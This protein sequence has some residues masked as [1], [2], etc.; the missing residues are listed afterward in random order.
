[1]TEYQLPA[2]LRD[3][4]SRGLAQ[5]A[6]ANIGAGSPPIVSLMGNR[7]TLVDAVGTDEQVTTHDPKLGVYLDCCVVDVGDHESKIYF[8]AA[9]DP[10]ATSWP[11]PKCWSD[12]GVAPS[13]Q[14]GEP[15]AR[16]CTP[17]PTGQFGCKWAVWGS[18]TSKVSGKGVPACG[19]YQKLAVVPV[20]DEMAFLLRVPPNSL[21]NLQAYLAKFK[22]DVGPEHVVTRIWFVSQG[23][24][25][26]S[27]VNYIDEAMAGVQ[28]KLRADKATD[29]LVGRNDQPIAL[30]P[31]GAALPAP[32]QAQEQPRP[33]P[34]RESAQSAV[35]QSTNAAMPSHSTTAAHPAQAASPSDPP[36][37]QGGQ[38]RRRRT[39]AEMAAASG[40]QPAAGGA[41]PFRPSEP[42]TGAQ[43][44][45]G[46]QDGAAPGADL[47]RELD[48]LFGPAAGR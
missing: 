3:L 8:G 32:Q 9:F 34:P 29:N 35:S 5:R 37:P 38:R 44:Q 22:G 17:D 30:A 23:T 46:M 40:G 1:M 21:S 18:A 28:K 47:D 31:A 33:L 4:P 14:A 48:G 41:A 11:P 42:P 27:A 15:Q 43:P 45:F 25:N 16:T 7:F 13:R 24:L 26:F 2:H 12:N 20:G 39:A 10:N 19:K 6:L 36:G